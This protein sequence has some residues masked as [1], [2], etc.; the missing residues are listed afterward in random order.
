M[1]I[2]KARPP[3]SAAIRIAF[4]LPHLSGP[5][6]KT[7]DTLPYFAPAHVR[8]RGVHRQSIRIHLPFRIFFQNWFPARLRTR[9]RLPLPCHYFCL[10]KSK[11][12]VPVAAPRSPSSRDSVQIGVGC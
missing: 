5:T 6:T 9:H 10:G 4:P 1:P 3:G 8:N 2:R 12:R 11:E 7:E